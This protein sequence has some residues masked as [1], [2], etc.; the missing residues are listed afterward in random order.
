M[1]NDKNKSVLSATE[2]RDRAEKRL[3]TKGFEAGAPLTAEETARLV[4]EFEIHQIELEMQNDELL[5]AKD[6]AE[7]AL[8][9]Y[10]ELYDFA[11]VGYFS[12]DGKGNIISMNLS[13]AK[14]LGVERGRLLGRRFGQF[15]ADNYR[16][17]F[18]TFFGGV[19]ASQVKATCEVALLTKE[20]LPLFVHIEAKAAASKQECRLALIDITGRRQAEEALQESEERMYRLA[21]MAVDAIVMLDENGRVTYCNAAA[22]KMFG[23]S[24][25]EMVGQQIDLLFSAEQPEG[26][27]DFDILSHGAGTGHSEPYCQTKN[28]Q[29]L[30]VQFTQSP[31]M[32]SEGQ[33]VAVSVIMSDISAIKEMQQQVIEANAH[34]NLAG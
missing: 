16:A 12:L 33:T 1:A 7:K 27:D 25:K 18:N 24:A 11:P 6:L 30:A 4:H 8:D 2:L 34:P 15:V 5:R 21:A 29:R 28:G 31:I 19:F 10:T 14:L 13:G 9:R 26:F 20:K 22:E 3:K 23:Y 17:D 32:G